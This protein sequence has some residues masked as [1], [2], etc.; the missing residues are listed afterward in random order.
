MLGALSNRMTR[1]L[2]EKV[3]GSSSSARGSSRRAVRAAEGEDVGAEEAE[4]DEED[5][6]RMGLFVTE[7]DCS[8]YFFHCLIRELKQE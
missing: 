3:N 6:V 7:K 8:L 4:S 1:D 2:L 5:E